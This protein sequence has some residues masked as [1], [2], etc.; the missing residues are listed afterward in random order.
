MREEY[1]YRVQSLNS[2]GRAVVEY[3]HATLGSV[4]RHMVLPYDRGP[5]QIHRKIVDEF[6]VDMFYSNMLRNHPQPAPMPIEGKMFIDFDD[7]VYD[8]SVM[9]GEKSSS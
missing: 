4:T 6:P 5:E 1:T 2:D 8:F 3:K 9:C 7:F